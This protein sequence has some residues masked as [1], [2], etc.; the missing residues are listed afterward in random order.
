MVGDQYSPGVKAYLVPLAAV[1]LLKLEV[2]NSPSALG[3]REI[4]H[5]F[6]VIG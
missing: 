1:L 5:K 2:V 3:F 6:I 4:G